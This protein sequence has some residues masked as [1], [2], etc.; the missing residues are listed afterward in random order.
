M[1][2][3]ANRLMVEIQYQTERVDLLIGTLPCIV[4][5]IVIWLNFRVFTDRKGT[6]NVQHGTTP[7][8]ILTIVVD[9]YARVGRWVIGTN[10]ES[11][12]DRQTIAVSPIEVSA[13]EVKL[14]PV[15]VGHG[16]SIFQRIA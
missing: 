15:A 9:F 12:F 3:M 5:V 8:I 13:L 6:A 1:C 10:P 7:L 4:L 2:P 16:N 14:S 11:P